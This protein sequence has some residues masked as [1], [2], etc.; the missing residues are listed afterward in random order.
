MVRA[1]PVGIPGQAGGVEDRPVPPPVWRCCGQER[2]RALRFTEPF[3]TVVR[4][5]EAIVAGITLILGWGSSVGDRD[6]PPSTS[7][8]SRRRWLA[9]SSQVTSLIGVPRVADQKQCL[10]AAR[11]RTASEA[12]HAML[13]SPLR[14]RSAFMCGLPTVADPAA[15]KVCPVPILRFEVGPK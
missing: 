11:I 6:I 14:S 5:S 4:P 7:A 12:C 9:T 2:R 8:R 1:R 13:T 10:K 15:H 3:G